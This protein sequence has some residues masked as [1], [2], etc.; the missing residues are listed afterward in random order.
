MK[1][2][3]RIGCWVQMVDH[4]ALPIRTYRPALPHHWQAR[5]AQRLERL[6]CQDKLLISQRLATGFLARGGAEDAG[7]AHAPSMAPPRRRRPVAGA[8]FGFSIAD[9]IAEARWLPPACATRSPGVSS[10]LICSWRR[11]PVSLSYVNLLAK[12]GPTRWRGFASCGRVGD[13]LERE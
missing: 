12:D 4:L 13:I 5:R 3:Q 9:G 2:R 10:G 8:D 1:A 11:R 7:F 6:V